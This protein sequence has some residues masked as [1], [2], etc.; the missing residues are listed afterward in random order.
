MKVSY[1]MNTT[2][3]MVWFVVKPR[4]NQSTESTEKVVSNNIILPQDES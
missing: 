4:G 1:C 2:G 3:H